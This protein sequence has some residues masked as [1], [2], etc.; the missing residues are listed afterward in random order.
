MIIQAS[1]FR[2]GLELGVFALDSAFSLS[3]LVS[4]IVVVRRSTGGALINAAHTL[5]NG[6]LRTP[7]RRMRKLVG[8][9][10]AE[11]DANRWVS[12]LLGQIWGIAYRVYAS[13]GKLK[14]TSP[15]TLRR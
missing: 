13:N 12:E 3:E 6:G 2:F 5:V 1:I 8:S 7:M 10:W 14:I 11:G 9:L 15:Q 4:L